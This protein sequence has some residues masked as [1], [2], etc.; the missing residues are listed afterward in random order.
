[1]IYSVDVITADTS[2]MR[3]RG[4][5]FAFT[6]S[7]YIITAFAGPKAAENFYDTNWRWAYG[8]WAIVLPVVAFPLFWVLFINQRK[9]KRNGLLVKEPSGRTWLQSIW[10]YTIEFDC[11]C[12]RKHLDFPADFLQWPALSSSLPDSSSSCFPSRLPNRQRKNGALLTSLS[13]SSLALLA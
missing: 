2:S 13:C 8:C 4:L 10:H 5:A 6:S 1:M 3:D 12:S 9:A 7:P 11:K